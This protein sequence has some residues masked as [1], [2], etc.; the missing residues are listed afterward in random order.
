MTQRCL[1]HPP[2]FAFSVE[3]RRGEEVDVT[4]GAIPNTSL[5]KVFYS[6]LPLQSGAV[7]SV[8]GDATSHALLTFSRGAKDAKRDQGKLISHEATKVEGKRKLAKHRQDVRVTRPIRLIGSRGGAE[9]R[10]ENHGIQRGWT[11]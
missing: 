4:F 9:T 1:Q 2:F 7:F 6:L 8:D 3:Q 11:T 10:R 5:R